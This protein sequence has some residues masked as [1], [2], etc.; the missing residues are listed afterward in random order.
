ML[1]NIGSMLSLLVGLWTFSVSGDTLTEIYR[2]PQQSWPAPHID[3]GAQYSPL[4]S[5]P[6]QPPYPSENPYSDAKRELGK[7][8]FFDRRLS[9]SQQIACASCHDPDL[10]WADGRRKSIGHNRQVH[11]LNTPT[12]VNTAYL[13]SVFWDGRV[14]SIEQ[15]VVRSWANPIEMAASLPEATARIDRLS[16]YTPFFENAFGTREVNTLRITQ[17][18]STFMRSLT[19]TKTKFDRFLRGERALFTES[20]IRGLH[21]FRTKAR[22]INCH[23][24]AQLSDGQ[25]HH[26]GTSFHLVG[27]FEGRYSV[28]GEAKDVGAFRTPNLRGLS[29]TAPYMHNGLIN[30]LDNLL[31]LYNN[32][33]WQ[34]AP[35]QD[36]KNT[37]P[38][39]TLSP[40]IQPLNLSKSEMADLLAFLGTLNGTMPFTTPP[41]ELN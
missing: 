30:N 27:N 4:A 6:V 9:K 16:E 15:Q 28:T 21:L 3:E 11:T 40:L 39:A 36:E 41:T 31:A 19:L 14:N 26:L 2:G 17:A 12:V 1:N 7:Y 24:G 29:H 22:C 33:W 38:L 23:N 5:L 13:T 32:G 18:I 20:E 8:L 10:G 35:V 34:N 25:F 37:V